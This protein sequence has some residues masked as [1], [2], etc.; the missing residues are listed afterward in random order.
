M[1]Q[2]GQ[3]A[4]DVLDA[5]SVR[6]RGLT[7]AAGTPADLALPCCLGTDRQRLSERKT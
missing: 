2:S 3:W 6:A 7:P 5:A 1:S 4:A